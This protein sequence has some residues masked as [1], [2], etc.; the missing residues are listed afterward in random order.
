[1]HQA[2]HTL[3]IE[4]LRELYNAENQVIE[5]LPQV[6]RVVSNNELRET[7]QEHLNEE[8]NHKSRLEQA[9]NILNES[10]EGEFCEGMAGLL[11]ECRDIVARNN[12]SSVEDA[13]LIGEI[14]KIEH[15]QIACYGT[16]RT[17]AQNLEYEEVKKLLQKSLDEEGNSNKKL[18]SLAEGSFF[19]SGVNAKALKE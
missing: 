9:F 19:W 13:A 17:F 10:P 15:Y 7:L 4:Q 6:I 3:F 18:T 16:L 14:Q 2:F 11:K 12:P 1:M 8:R 5:A